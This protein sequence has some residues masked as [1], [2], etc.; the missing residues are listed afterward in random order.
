MTLGPKAKP[1]VAPSVV[2]IPLRVA[3]DGAVA[4][5]ISNSPESEALFT[6][7]VGA[8]WLHGRRG[9]RASRRPHRVY[10]RANTN[11]WLRSPGLSS[12]V[13]LTN[14]SAKPEPPVLAATYCLPP[15]ENV[16]G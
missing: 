12:G 1:T 4:V 2:R 16:T 7:A 13:K 9:A 10:G 5:C 8:A 14:P 3:S 15:T 11:S 6:A